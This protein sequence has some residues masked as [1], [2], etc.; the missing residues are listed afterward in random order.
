M[1]LG[2]AGGA[3]EE[4][5]AYATGAQGFRPADMR[6]PGHPVHDRGHGHE[7]G[8]RAPARL[9][10]RHERRPGLPSM[11]ESAMAKCFANE[12]AVEV[13]NAA[14]QVFGGYGY[15]KEFPVKGCTGTRWPGGLPAAR[16]RCCGSRWRASFS[17][18]ASTREPGRDCRSPLDPKVSS[19]VCLQRLSDFFVHFLMDT[20]ARLSLP[21]CLVKCSPEC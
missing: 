16:S 8:R 9:S 3:L 6:V 4:A 1:C 7:A 15:S 5:K 14:M 2:V 21:Y 13:T 11:Y 18:G 20:W 10:G 17:A 19:A 12:M